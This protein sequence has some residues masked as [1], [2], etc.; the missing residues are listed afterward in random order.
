MADASRDARHHFCVYASD[1]ELTAGSFHAANADLAHRL[2]RVLRLRA[3]ENVQLFNDTHHALLT[4]QETKNWKKEVNG[5]LTQVTATVARTPA[6]HV[7]IGL[8]KP[9]ALEQAVY[10]ASAAG[11]SSI[12]PIITSKS[13]KELSDRERERL[14]LQVIAA[15]EQAKNVQIPQLHT[16]I[17][18]EKFVQSEPHGRYWFDGS[19]APLPTLIRE[20]TTAHSP[21]LS[22]LIGAE[23]GFTTV[24]EALIRAH[25]WPAYCLTPTVLRAVEAVTVAVS[26]VSGSVAK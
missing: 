21:S 4:L 26:V 23:A 18:L 16:P 22:L 5:T 1:L 25:H 20:L 19:G 2:H 3:G 14:R 17:T 9:A 8:L 15:C 7:G 6:V 13:G 12:T 11:A 24:E 10:A